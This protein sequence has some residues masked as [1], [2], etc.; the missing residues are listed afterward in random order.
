RLC[1]A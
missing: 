1:C